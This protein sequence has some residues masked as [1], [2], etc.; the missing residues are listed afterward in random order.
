MKAGLTR[1]KI[2]A[3]M[4]SV[5]VRVPDGV[6]ARIRA[7]GGMAEINVNRDRFP[8]SGDNYQS[9][10]YDSAEHKVEIDAETGMGS[11]RIA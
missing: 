11:L 6:A 2:R 1:A 8:R 4:A 9:P 3:G 7:K 5:D 10:D